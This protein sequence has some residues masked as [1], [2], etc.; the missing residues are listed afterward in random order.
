MNTKYNA[1][2]QT[3]ALVSIEEALY[4]GIEIRL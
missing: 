1:P 4:H 3:R 2:D